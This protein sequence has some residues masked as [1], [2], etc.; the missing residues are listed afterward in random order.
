M[1]LLDELSAH[2]HSCVRTCRGD[3][4]TSA[5]GH[6]YR[7]FLYVTKY[8]I[9]LYTRS[10]QQLLPVWPRNVW[11][12]I[13]CFCLSTWTWCLWGGQ[14]SSDMDGHVGSHGIWMVYRHATKYPV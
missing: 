6:F 13:L 11:C 10:L 12:L 4:Q 5:S 9:Y 3:I 8:E 1:M 2:C 14:T 7:C